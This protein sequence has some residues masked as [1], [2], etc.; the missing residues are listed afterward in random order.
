LGGLGTRDGEV[1]GL[2]SA[3][4]GNVSSSCKGQPDLSSPDVQDGDRLTS[5]TY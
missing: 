2:L 5:E 3:N 1:E 4:F